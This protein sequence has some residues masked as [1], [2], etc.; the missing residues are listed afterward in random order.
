MKLKRLTKYIFE[1]IPLLTVMLMGTAIRLCFVTGMV[2]WDDFEYARLA[3]N[4]SQG[5]IPT[6]NWEGTARVV[7]Y[8]PVAVLYKL[9]GVNDITSL[10]LPFLYSILGIIVIYFISRLLGGELAGLI[11]ATIWSVFPLN[12]S[13][14]TALLPDSMLALFVLGSVLCFLIGIRFQ[15][16]AIS[17]VFY[18][19]SVTILIISVFIKPAGL[20]VMFF[21]ILYILWKWLEDK[22]FNR[23]LIPGFLLILAVVVY[24]Y[25]IYEGYIPETNNISPNFLTI[26]AQ[27]STD[28]FFN[29]V[30]K[31][32]FSFLF[33]LFLIT[34]AM[35]L[36]Q[37]D[38]NNVLPLLWFGTT[39]LYFEIGSMGLNKYDPIPSTWG[40]R[41]ILYVISPLVVLTGLY[42]GRV[43]NNLFL[44]L[45]LT[46]LSIFVTLI[47]VFVS[48][49]IQNYRVD[50]S[51]PDLFLAFSQISAAFVIFGG[52]ASSFYISTNSQKI[53]NLFIAF[54]LTFVCVGSVYPT[55]ILVTEIN[56]SWIGVYRHV[57]KEV[58]KKPD[59]PI[60]VQNPLVGLRL[61]YQTGFQYGFTSDPKKAEGD[62]FRIRFNMPDKSL[63]KSA[64]VLVD[65][66][67]VNDKTWGEPPVY[68]TNPPANWLLLDDFGNFK[69]YEYSTEMDNLLIKQIK[70]DIQQQPSQENYERLMTL[71]DAMGDFCLKISAWKDLV[72]ILPDAADWF[73]PS[74]DIIKCYLNQ[75]DISGIVGVN[76]ISNGDFINGTEGWYHD[77]SWQSEIKILTED[78]SSCL[79]INFN[80][81]DPKTIR[82]EV[83]LKPDTWYVFKEVVK[84][85]MPVIAL[86]V[87]S[88][89]PVYLEEGKSYIDWSPITL[90]F[91]TPHWDGAQK[92]IN[93]YPVLVTQSGSAWVKN[94]QLF[95]INLTLP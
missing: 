65:Q 89:P 94:L 68:V 87:E 27:T 79:Q 88:D 46:A 85:S 64:Y 24:I 90:V 54:L 9:F 78:A 18:G 44:K 77:E 42:L 38:K 57:V 58:E 66:T 1:V 61:D 62:S 22:H 75:A 51:Q 15:G 73:D 76:L 16:Q 29:L 53:K 55:N 50:G 71:A 70:N 45:Y 69:L 4:L 32:E 41:Q 30:V 86:F 13:T 26:L 33:P 34:I 8:G 63:I 39:Y 91:K 2:Y 5:I 40:T 47:V 3:H 14:A 21:Y 25:T 37:G 93:I 10:A 49:Y 81:G 28:W 23:W 36:L 67:Q 60:F 20:T 83:R 74:P 95:E 72:T 7:F 19:L 84:T 6:E 31:N 59:Y 12:V 11:T 82:Q 17:F 48:I 43:K 92:P 80:N 52:L 56:D 35:S